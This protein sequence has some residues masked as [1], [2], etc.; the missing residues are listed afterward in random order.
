M[1]TETFR[2]YSARLNLLYAR[3]F[4]TLR[5]AFF[6]AAPRA[7]RARTER[8]EQRWEGEGGKPKN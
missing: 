7:V 5:T 8:P 4:D 3:Y 2:E 6:P 1:N